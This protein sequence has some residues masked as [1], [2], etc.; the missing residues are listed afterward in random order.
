MRLLRNLLN[1]INMQ[2]RV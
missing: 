1:S 2:K